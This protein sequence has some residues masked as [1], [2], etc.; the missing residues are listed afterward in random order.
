VSF[1]VSLPVA[2]LGERQMMHDLADRP[3]LLARLP[4]GLTLRKSFGFPQDVGAHRLELRPQRFDG[5]GKRHGASIP[6]FLARTARATV[7]P[8]LGRQEVITS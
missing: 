7:Q 6:P 2:N 1:V 8:P 3:V 5:L 4:V